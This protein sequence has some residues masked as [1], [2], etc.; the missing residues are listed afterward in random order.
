MSQGKKT[1][2]KYCRLRSQRC[3]TLPHSHCTLQ[4]NVSQLSH[5]ISKTFDQMEF[6]RQ[7]QSHDNK[8]FKRLNFNFHALNLLSLPYFLS[9]FRELQRIESISSAPVISHFSETIL[10]LT[11]IRAYN[12]ESRFMEMLFKRMEANNVAFVILNSSN[13]WLGISLVRFFFFLHRYRLMGKVRVKIF[14]SIF[15]LIK[16]AFE[17]SRNWRQILSCLCICRIIWVQ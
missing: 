8:L 13:R 15:Q 7:F 5:Q 12:Q 4:F 9:S 3:L 14:S 2:A 1:P 6:L 16:F 10:G 17:S 11:T